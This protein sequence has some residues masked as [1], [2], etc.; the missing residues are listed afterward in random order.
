[1]RKF[2]INKITLI[3]CSVIVVICLASSQLRQT[4][5]NIS[6]TKLL[7]SGFIVKKVKINDL[8][9]VSRK[10]VQALII[11]E[12]NQ[13]NIL[14][15]NKSLLED[16]VTKLE[17]VKSAEITSNLS[18]EL[19]VKIVEHKPKAFYKTVL[20]Y[21]IIDKNAKQIMA[22]YDIGNFD[23]ILPQLVG[24]GALIN[25]SEI[26]EVL[27]YDTKFYNE[28]KVFERVGQRRWNLVLFNGITIMLPEDDINE[29]WQYFLNFQQEF[30]VLNSEIKSIDLRTKDRLFIEFNKELK[31][32][33]LLQ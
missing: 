24:E 33:K 30:Q 10:A 15:L 28:I 25:A 3:T 7:E 20:D 31:N 19:I 23:K 1:M 22:L 17:W 2:L 8:T 9:F 21:K 16:Q 27:S 4:I 6:N 12:T 32:V 18:N 29:N 11:K 13:T 5:Y 26:I 14:F